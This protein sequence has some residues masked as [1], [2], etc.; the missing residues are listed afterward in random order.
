MT[1]TIKGLKFEIKKEKGIS[2]T[3]HH[4]NQCYNGQP[5]GRCE[6]ACG[7]ANHGMLTKRGIKVE[8]YDK[9][10]HKGPFLEARIVPAKKK[11]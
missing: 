9:K 4:E 10:K 11:K 5:G 1:K 3:T 7:G 2:C 6:C 8:K